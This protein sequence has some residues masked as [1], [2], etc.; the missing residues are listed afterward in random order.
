[1]CL[2]V[3]KLAIIIQYHIRDNM[4][5][6]NYQQQALDIMGNAQ[7]AFIRYP[8]RQLGQTTANVLYMSRFAFE[9]QNIRC[10]YLVPTNSQIQLCINQFKD[11]LQDMIIKVERNRLL[12]SNGSLIIFRNMHNLFNIGEISLCI[13]DDLSQ[14]NNGKLDAILPRLYRNN[15]KIFATSIE[16]PTIPFDRYVLIGNTKT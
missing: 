8:A 11:T 12:L 6:N 2:L 4:K 7:R 3:N 16:D 15:S 9:H 14:S 1:M 13:V 5:P 10:S